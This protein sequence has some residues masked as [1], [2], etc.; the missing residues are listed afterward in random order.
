MSNPTVGAVMSGTGGMRKFRMA[1]EGAGKSGGYRICYVIA[2]PDL[3]L[4]VTLFS[5]N[6]QTTLTR[7]QCGD[8][9]RVVDYARSIQWR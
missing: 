4:L 7:E 3:V 2:K 5:K 1:I 9:K 6:D 8:F